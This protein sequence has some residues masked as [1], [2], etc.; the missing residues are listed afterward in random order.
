MFCRKDEGCDYEELE[1]RQTPCLCISKRYIVALMVSLG[2][3]GIYTARIQMSIGI[4]AMT[5][6]NTHVGNGSSSSGYGTRFDW[7][8]QV[9]GYVLTA[10]YWGTVITQYPGGLLAKRF[11]GT[12]IFGLGVLG[13]ALCSLIIP[14]ASTWGVYAVITIRFLQGTFD[15]VTT[16]ATMEIWTRWAP[17][18]EKS[19]LVSLASVGVYMGCFFGLFVSGLL[20]ETSLGW[21]LMFYFFGGVFVVWYLLW[22]IC[23]FESPE[24]HT[25]IS[26]GELEYLKNNAPH[27][28]DIEKKSHKTP[29]FSILTSMPYWSL[30]SVHFAIDW[31][32]FM[33][34]T[35]ISTFMDNALH[36]EIKQNGLLAALP[37]LFMSVMVVITGRVADWL[38][39]RKILTTTQARK[40]P[41]CGVP[42]LMCIIMITA[43]IYSQSALIT[44]I[45]LSVTLILQSATWSGV[46]VNF[47]DLSPNYSTVL[48]AISN[49]L[50]FLAGV[51]SPGLTGTLVNRGGR[52]A[53]SIV[54]YICSGLYLVSS[55]LYGIFGSGKTQSWDS[56][57][58]AVCEE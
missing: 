34:M 24:S 45:C 28:L 53:W 49:A 57:T 13:T 41:L 32:L 16:P 6:N 55:A 7:N 29:W 19:Q 52:E 5:T 9:Q 10:I 40:L 48:V 35:D 17:V 15:G 18:Q 36:F 12:V 56:E 42:L 58:D 14:W 26:T 8:L 43:G 2:Y 21:P 51:V 11:G 47:L 4:I 50:A 39:N 20:A 33:L 1:K 46:I 44:V 22:Y 54:F 37:Y 31:G 23:I 3:V 38:I 30:V 25:S 27:Y